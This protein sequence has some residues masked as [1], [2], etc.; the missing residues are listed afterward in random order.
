MDSAVLS[1]NR[2]DC[3]MKSSN[4]TTPRTLADCSFEVGHY[5]YRPISDEP[6]IWE[7]IIYGTI[8]LAMFGG[9]LALM[10]SY[11]DVLVK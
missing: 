2:K 11:F 10:L 4:I 3:E 9:L 5:T 6:T 7:F 8:G 1:S